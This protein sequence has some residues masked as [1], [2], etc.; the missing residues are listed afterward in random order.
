MVR[1]ILQRADLLPVTGWTPSPCFGGGVRLSGCGFRCAFEQMCK[2]SPRLLA[3][4][5]HKKATR[6]CMVLRHRRRLQVLCRNA[7]VEKC[8]WVSNSSDAILSR[9]SWPSALLPSAAGVGYGHCIESEEQSK[10]PR[11]A[12]ATPR[13]GAAARQ[14]GSQATHCL[15][16][17][18]PP[19]SNSASGSQV[20]VMGGCSDTETLRSCEK[21]PRRDFGLNSEGRVCS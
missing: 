16:S 8:V 2:A 5:A 3:R 12:L 10:P 21:L 20:F 13:W 11:P 1:F 6:C 15:I 7:C 9:F 17:R 19:C 14:L 4:L 18:R